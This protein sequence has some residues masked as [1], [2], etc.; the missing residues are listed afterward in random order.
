MGRLSAFF[1]EEFETD[2]K[3]NK[4]YDKKRIIQIEHA[5]D[6]ISYY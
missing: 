2:E 6:E 4:K 3:G 1:E 5:E